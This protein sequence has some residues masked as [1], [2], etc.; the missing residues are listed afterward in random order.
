M[1]NRLSRRPGLA[2]LSALHFELLLGLGM[3]AA[4]ALSAFAMTWVIARSSG[5]AT[6]GQFQLA[7]AT[8]SILALVTLQ[9][10]DRVIIRAA[11][12]AFAR[13]Q[14]GEALNLF[15]AACW[16][17]MLVGLP[18]VFGLV[19]LAGP[20]GL[21]ILDEPAVAVHLRILA[22][23]VIGLSI[24]RSSSALLRAKGSILI[25]QSVDGVAYTTLAVIAIG[26][27][28]LSGSGVSEFTP[29]AVYLVSVLAVALAGFGVAKA[30]LKGVARQSGPV[31]LASGLF[32][33]G[34]NVLSAFGDWIALFLL[35]AY[36]SSADAGIY[37]AG[38]QVCLLFTLVN[39]SFSM[40]AGTRLATAFAAGDAQS[41]KQTV[42]A[43]S[44][45][46][47]LLVLPLFLLVLFAAEPILSI[48]G[49][50]F[51]A[52]ANALRILAIGQFLNV[53]AGPAGAAL[54][55]MHRERSVLLIEIA[56]TLA[57][58]ALLVWLLPSHGILAAAAAAASAAAIRN[59][60]S[61][62]V[63]YRAL[64]GLNPNP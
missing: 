24:I 57:T 29:S 15:I 48:F 2:R 35:T 63:M 59:G 42:R 8:V 53:A 19:L 26:I 52:G 23:A 3:R 14:A 56:T 1:R 28:V 55:M 27:A 46:G 39:A 43:T 16:R 58:I 30:A 45:L 41:M 49:E 38:F 51:V 22:P 17:Q 18:I 5:A 25:S 50:D 32:I 7:V 21:H 64:K 34:F 4:G 9:G 44:L 20:V 10:L 11:S 47:T 12:P 6:F 54:T 33:A 61:L 13:Q 31:A 37:R 62:I 40:M 36:S 60:A